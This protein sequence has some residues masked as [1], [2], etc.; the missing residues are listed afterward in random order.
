MKIGVPTISAIAFSTIVNVL[1]CH[2]VRERINDPAH[3]V[4]VRQH[5]KLVRVHRRAHR[6]TVNVTR[7][8]VR[9]KRERL[10]VRVTIREHGK[11]VRG[12]ANAPNRSGRSRLMSAR[13][14]LTR[15]A[16]IRAA[17]SSP[18]CTPGVLI[19]ATARS[20]LA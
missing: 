9:T 10:T 3:W 12:A 7:C 20:I 13:Y 18:R 15:R 6:K 8:H 2:P 4:R 5:H 16:R 19:D 17:A 14:S 11:K 1:R